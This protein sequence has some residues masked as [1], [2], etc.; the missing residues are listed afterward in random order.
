MGH[1]GVRAGF[2][3]VWLVFAIREPRMTWWTTVRKSACG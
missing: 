2:R 1:E 3:A